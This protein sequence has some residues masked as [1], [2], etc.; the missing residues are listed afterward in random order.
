[1]AYKLVCTHPFHDHHLGRVI[2]RGEEIF[3]QD[4]MVKLIDGDRL[5]HFRRAALGMEPAQWSWPPAAKTEI[6]D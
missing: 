4:H 1:M 3:E 5:H 6:V 2:E